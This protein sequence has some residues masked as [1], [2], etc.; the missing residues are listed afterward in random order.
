MGKNV[1]KT[2]DIHQVIRS[3]SP[4]LAQSIPGFVLRYLQRII[5]E[6][7]LN[8]AMRQFGHTQG[9][10]YI[11]SMLDFLGTTVEV[12]GLEHI[13]QEGGVV[14]ASNHPLGGLDGMAL[15]HAVG[16]RRTDI[17]FLVN[18]ILLNIKNLE[19]LFVPVNKVGVNPRK[20]LQMIEE[21]YASDGAI[22][23]FPAGLVSRKLPEGI[24]D[25]PW[26]KSFVARAIKYQKPIIPVHIGGRNSHF[27]YN[28]AR[29][30][31]RLGIKANIEMFYLSDELFKQRNQTIHIT[32]GEPTHWSKFKDGTPLYDWAQ[33]LRRQVYQLPHL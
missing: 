9:L 15:M 2:I 31:Q 27:F 21:T 7:E 3:K 30:R 28:L 1:S 14:L 10:E 20:A 17:H 16:Q 19:S 12:H 23:V 8:E 26:Q 22:L 24:A 5:H 13:P 11:Q 6:D 29:W 33:E 4:T 32:V 25:L 18:D